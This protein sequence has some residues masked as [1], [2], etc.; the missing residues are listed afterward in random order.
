MAQPSQAT[1]ETTVQESLAY[2]KEVR[3]T[4]EPVRK[5]IEDS[6]K[7]LAEGKHEESLRKSMEAIAAVSA[8]FTKDEHKGI[9]DKAQKSV[10]KA[11]AHFQEAGDQ[12]GE[13]H[14]LKASARIQVTKNRP[15]GA[16]KTAMQAASLFRVKGDKRGE[17]SSMITVVDAHLSKA[18]LVGKPGHVRQTANLKKTQSQVEEENRAEALKH[19]EDAMNAAREVVELFRQANEKRGQADMLC[20]LADINITMTEFERAKEVS[21]LARDLYLDLDD[22]RG[23]Q[24]ALELEHDAHIKSFDGEEALNAAQEMVKMFRQ[25]GER[26]GEAEGMFLV[27]KTHFQMG[28]VEEL[29]KVGQD[30]R[31]LTDKAND[32]EMGGIILDSMMK[33]QTHQGNDEEALKFATEAI[34]VYRK[35]NHKKGEAAALHACAGIMLDKFFK[36][37]DENMKAFRESGYNAARF[38]DFDMETY[39]KALGM[40]NQAETIY[41]DMN[42]KEGLEQILETQ[43]N[44]TIRAT[45]LNEP[46][47]TKQVTKDGK[48]HEV[49]HTWTIPD[50]DDETRPLA[51]APAPA[52]AE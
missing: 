5:T 52:D 23:A 42:D 31:S 18:A 2:C 26:R 37:S 38:R 45:M 27:M 20:A 13:A 29:M 47:E 8:H 19:Q 17:A 6:E 43:Q 49:V 7:L 4:A 1:P 44:I 9:R 46:D 22:R 10:N 21:M 3:G 39:D 48:L 24:K 15:E 51:D 25:A 16:K 33:A 12:L 36:E 34:D 30:A 41:R 28:N 32:V 14:A 11:L 50:P 40:V 35:G